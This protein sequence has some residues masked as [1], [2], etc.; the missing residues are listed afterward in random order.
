VEEEREDS[1]GQGLE[2][3]GKVLGGSAHQHWME[4]VLSFVTKNVPLRVERKKV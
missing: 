2:V 1:E 3:G 4:S